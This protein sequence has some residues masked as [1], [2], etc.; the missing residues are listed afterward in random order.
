MSELLEIAVFLV[1]VMSE[2]LEI[3]VFPAVDLVAVAFCEKGATCNEECMVHGAT[4]STT[5]VLS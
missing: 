2:L 1:E 4:F 3:T 5:P